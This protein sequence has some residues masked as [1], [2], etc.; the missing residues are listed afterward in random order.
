MAA[1]EKMEPASK[2]KGDLRLLKASCLLATGRAEAAKA[3][4]ENLSRTRFPDEAQWLLAL[5]FLKN[6][7][8]GRTKAQLR[9]IADDTASSRQDEA[10]RLLK[11]LD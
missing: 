2:D 5:A 10:A 9:K 1:F 11:E 6:G 3:V 4:L 8:M 7:E